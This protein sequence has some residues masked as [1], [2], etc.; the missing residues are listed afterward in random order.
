MIFTAPCLI[1]LFFIG[2]MSR[3]PTTKYDHECRCICECVCAAGRPLPPELMRDLTGLTPINRLP[4]PFCTCTFTNTCRSD[5][6]R[7]PP[8]IVP[9]GWTFSLL[10]WCWRERQRKWR[11]EGWKESRMEGSSRGKEEEGGDQ[12]PRERTLRDGAGDKC[13]PRPLFQLRN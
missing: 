10:A 2:R 6:H 4:S 1:A 7:F 5:C 13:S 3:M 8:K 11:I 12:L 9:A